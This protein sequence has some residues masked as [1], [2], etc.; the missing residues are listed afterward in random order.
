MAKPLF[1][2]GTDTDIGKTLVAE[3]LLKKFAVNGQTT[4]AL[5]PIAAGCENT[6]QG[7]RNDDAVALQAA[8]TTQLPY[9]QVNPI[10]L[11]EACAPHIAAGNE[12]RRLQ[13]SRVEGICRGA[14]MNSAD[15]CIIEGAGGWR[16]P[17]NERESISDLAVALNTPVVLVVGMRLGCLNHAILTA[18]AIARDGL[19]LVGWVANCIDEQMPHLDENIDTLRHI[20][21][22][23]CLGVVPKMVGDKLAERA[24]RLLALPDYSL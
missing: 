4:I 16:V 2:A 8:A 7:L 19:K 13:V 21:P 14:L 5:K 24:S 9:A 23:P 17:L 12:G 15:V 18:E 10:A 11:Q 3:A 1:I 20:L 6:E 22:A